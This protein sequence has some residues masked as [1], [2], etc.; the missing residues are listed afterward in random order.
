MRGPLPHYIDTSAWIALAITT[1][2]LH[3]RAKDTWTRLTQ[4]GT[5]LFTS[6]PVI[7]ETFTFLDRNTNRRTALLWKEALVPLKRFQ[8]L[9]CS[10]SDL[11]KAWAWFHRQ[12]LHKLSAVDATSFVLMQKHR[13]SR[14]FT[15][16][17]HFAIAGFGVV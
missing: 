14:A 5:R 12:D 2:P 4:D 6:V 13:I 15:F 11:Q 17:T 10:K 7:I 9:E 3:T 1:D 16:D 8:V